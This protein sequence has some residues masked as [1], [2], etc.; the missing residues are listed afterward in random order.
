ME[1]SI[2][3]EVVFVVFF[4]FNFVTF[5]HNLFSNCLCWYTFEKKK[6]Y[7]CVSLCEYEHVHAGTHE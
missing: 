4:F 7:I 2:V 3:I 5:I 6:P 1:G